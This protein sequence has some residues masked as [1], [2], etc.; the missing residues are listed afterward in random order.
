MARTRHRIHQSQSTYFDS[1]HFPTSPSLFGPHVFS[2]SSITP[3]SD[4]TL[5]SWDTFAGN[6]TYYDSP[7][8]F[9]YTIANTFVS[10]AKHAFASG[11]TWEEFEREERR[12]H[13]REVARGEVRSPFEALLLQAGC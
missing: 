3:D 6:P 7:T 4:P 13:S 12:G 5:D 9:L 10:R 8:A 1:V 2:I 11:K